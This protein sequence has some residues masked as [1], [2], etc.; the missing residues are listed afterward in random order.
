MHNLL[1]QRL[2]VVFE[3]F[4]PRII[5][6]SVI[7][8]LG[9]AP[10]DDTII[11]LRSTSYLIPNLSYFFNSSLIRTI[12]PWYL[13]LSPLL[14]FCKV[15]LFVSSTAFP[16]GTDILIKLSFRTSIPFFILVIQNCMSSLKRA[17]YSKLISCDSPKSSELISIALFSLNIC[18]SISKCFSITSTIILCI[19]LCL[20]VISTLFLAQLFKMWNSKQN[21]QFPKEQFEFKF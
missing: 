14:I 17:N 4:S 6:R 3:T 20:F 21:L 18:F 15:V 2:I 9:T 16:N 8:K 10:S 1:P 19:L 13:V 7:V 11:V 5:L 12:N